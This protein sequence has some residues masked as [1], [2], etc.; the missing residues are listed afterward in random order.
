MEEFIPLSLNYIAIILSFYFV[1][2]EI[3]KPQKNWLKIIIGSA[4]F[5]FTMI[6]GTIDT[7]KKVNGPKEDKKK[8]IDT[9]VLV[10]NKLKKAID[11][12]RTMV[13]DSVQDQIRSAIQ[14]AIGISKS[15]KDKLLEKLNQNS[16]QPLLDLDALHGPNPITR[17]TDSAKAKCDIIL[18][19]A[20]QRESE[21]YAK[22]K[23]VVYIDYLNNKIKIL[24][25]TTSPVTSSRQ[26]IYF[27]HS[28]ELDLKVGIP[29]QF[30][31]IFKDFE[32]LICF[33]L[34]YTNKYNEFQKPF[35]RIFVLSWNSVTGEFQV[36]RELGRYN[37]IEDYL[38]K[39]KYW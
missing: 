22:V 9:T 29:F 31:M 12:T 8:I 5:L 21:A 7:L 20:N 28:N 25:T 35:R 14:E 33:E 6:F 27:G 39:H 2:Q 11:S 23:K 10:G 3:L 30:P 34:T 13:I 24:N 18:N 36:K 32:S 17:I 1:F 15:D 4:F 16:I 37:E 19:I 26:P 38:I